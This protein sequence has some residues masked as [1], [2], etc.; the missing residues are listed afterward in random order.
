MKIV[1][2]LRHP[3]KGYGVRSGCDAAGDAATSGHPLAATPMNALD[4]GADDSSF[5]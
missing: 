5:F 4:N 2:P 3:P 1:C